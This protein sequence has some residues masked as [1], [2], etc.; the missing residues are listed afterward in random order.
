M[1]RERIQKV[2]AARGI[3]SRRAAEVMIKAGRVKVNGHP[4]G[5]GDSM[6]PAKDMLSVDGQTIRPERRKTYR[7]LMLNKPRGYLTTASDERGRRTVMDLLDGV[8]DR[9][10]PVGRLDMNSEG[11]LLLTNDGEFANQITHPSH[12]VSKLYRATV[13]PQ[14]TEEQIAKLAAGVTLD[15]G[16]RTQPARVR[17]VADGEGRS[18][19]EIVV[20]EGKNRQIR[21]M[22][23]AVGLDVARLRRNAVGP[24]KLGMLKSGQWRE[25]TLA[26][27]KALRASA[28]GPES[29]K[30]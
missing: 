11:L 21:R 25:L 9:V 27:V 19:L 30:K 5:L 14:A 22:C 3:C 1:A 29:K 8:E 7:Y 18:V 28:T 6:D 24:V 20:Q 17:V 26:E 23:E 13:R 10:Y 4:V 12:K 16:S 15:D 2:M